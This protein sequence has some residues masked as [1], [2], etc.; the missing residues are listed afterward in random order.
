MKTCNISSSHLVLG[1][2]V[3]FTLC[4]GAILMSSRVTAND[5]VVDDISITVPASCSMGGEIATGQEHSASLQNGIWSG[6]NDDYADG[7]GKTTITTFCNDYNG[8]SIYAVGFTGDVIDSGD[9]NKLIGVNTGFEIDTG[10]YEQGDT[11]SSWSMKVTKVTDPSETDTPAN[12]EITNSFNSWH[13]VPATYTQVAQYKAETGSSA[14]IAETD[15]GLGAKV[16]TTYAAY[17]SQT[18]AADQYT[19]KVKYTIVHPAD[20]TTPVAPLAM[21]NLSSASCTLK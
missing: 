10:V 2:L 8:F 13:T 6:D 5:S 9:N 14:T 17:I 19:G 18:Q 12:M 11:E 3:A 20:A 15:G 1:G 4:T 21:Q 7:I 16:E